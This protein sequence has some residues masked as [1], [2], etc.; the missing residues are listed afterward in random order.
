MALS[1][2]SCERLA[3]L[4]ADSEGRGSCD[5]HRIDGFRPRLAKLSKLSTASRACFPCLCGVCDCDQ[6]ARKGGQDG[7]GRGEARAAGCVWPGG[8]VGPGLTRSPHQL[9]RRRG[10]GGLPRH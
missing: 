3:D 2:E 10:K 5:A 1:L 8:V 4:K 7:P 9:V 6:G